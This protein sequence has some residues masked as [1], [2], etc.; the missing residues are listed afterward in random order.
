MGSG[1]SNALFKEGAVFSGSI[2][3]FNVN[4]A[5]AMSTLVMNTG[6]TSVLNTGWTPAC[7]GSTVG[8]ANTAQIEAL[9]TRKRI[10][11]VRAERHAAGSSDRDQPTDISVAWCVRQ[12]RGAIEAIQRA[13]RV[14]VAI[15]LARGKE[16]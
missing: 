5:P 11:I 12:H 14:R 8:G 1:A 16:A 13:I 10:R 2:V 3:V 15:D 7:A 4:I 6:A 9:A